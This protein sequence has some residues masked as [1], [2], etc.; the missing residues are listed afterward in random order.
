[1]SAGDI[2]DWWQPQRRKR[3]GGTHSYR[4][5]APVEVANL[6]YATNRKNGREALEYIEAGRLRPA[7]EATNSMVIRMDPDEQRDYWRGSPEW[8]RWV[9]VWAV[10]Y[11][12]GSPVQNV[13]SDVPL[14]PD[15]NGPSVD[16]ML[17]MGR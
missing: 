12:N 11:R 8:T 9:S 17:G 14:W 5:F 3:V 15:D 7:L 4:N 10:A 16:F 13:P 6:I 1:M 2:P